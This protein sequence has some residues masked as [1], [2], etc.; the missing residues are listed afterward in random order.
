MKFQTVNDVDTLQLDAILLDASGNVKP[1]PAAVIREIP[2][3]DFRLWCHRRAVYGYPTTEL[4]SRLKTI[5]PSDSSKAL[6]IGS[7]NG[8]FGRTLDIRA[9]DNYCQEIPAVKDYYDALGQPRIVYGVDVENIDG[10]AAVT[11]YKPTHVFASWVT[12]VYVDGLSV[13]G[14]AYGVDERKLLQEVDY[15]VFFGHKGVHEHKDIFRNPNL[16]I[17]EEIQSKDLVS[18]GADQSQN[19]LWVFSLKS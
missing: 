14:N 12:Q 2:W 19:V 4:I 6:E 13:D 1:V 9:T 3:N 17:E 8:C 16:V 10:N 18:R 5:L 7:G 11:K 15:Y